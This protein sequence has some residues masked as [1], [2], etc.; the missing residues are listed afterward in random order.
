M[1]DTDHHRVLLTDEDLWTPERRKR[2]AWRPL[3]AAGGLRY[4]CGVFVDSNSVWVADTFHHR[5]VVFDH[6]GHEVDDFSGYG[7]G[8]GR[9]AYPTSITRWKDLLFIADSEA[10]RVQAFEVDDANHNIGPLWGPGLIDG[11]L[12]APWVGHPFGISVNHN[13]RLAV[14][15]RLRRC[16]WLI[17]VPALQADWRDH[18]R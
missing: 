1:A 17:D 16:V 10:R 18:N 13:G 12:G 4:P 5:L 3:V 8:P 15:D 6:E 2:P 9:F 7:W 14:A 11:E